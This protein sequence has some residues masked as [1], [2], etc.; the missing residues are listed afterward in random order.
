MSYTRTDIDHIALYTGSLFLLHGTPDLVY[1]NLTHTEEV[2]KR[3]REIAAH[4][5][6]TGS[7]LF[8]VVAAAWFHD[9]GHLFTDY[10]HHEQK[11][12]E[13]MRSYCSEIDVEPEVI[14]N[15]EKCILATKFPSHPATL[16]EMILCD[17]D[18][19]HLGTDDFFAIDIQVKKEV[20]IRMHLNV[21]EWNRKTYHFLTQHRYFTDYCQLLLNAK[22][23][24]NMRLLLG[25]DGQ[26]LSE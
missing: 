22:K 9:T 24:Q 26:A 13:I 25:M 2:V 7:A 1:H 20:E 14:D 21:A 6:L 17:A 5:Q 19:Y 16:A 10:S 15:I 18:T 23:E 12:A 4:Y 11:S 3:A 8:T